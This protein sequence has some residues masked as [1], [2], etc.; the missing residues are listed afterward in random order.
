MPSQRLGLYQGLL[1]LSGKR[2]DE[3]MWNCT[4]VLRSRAALNRHVLFHFE[5]RRKDQWEKRR[6]SQGASNMPV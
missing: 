6:E 2:V 1:S 4:F 3:Y 5:E